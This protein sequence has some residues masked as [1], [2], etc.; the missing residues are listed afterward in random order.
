MTYTMIIL[1]IL[2]I[3]FYLLAITEAHSIV[4]NNTYIN[5]NNTDNTY[6]NSLLEEIDRL[7]KEVRYYTANEEEKAKMKKEYEDRLEIERQALKL[8][9]KELEIKKVQADTSNMLTKLEYSRF[10]SS[11]KLDDIERNMKHVV[12]KMVK[13]YVEAKYL[14]APDLKNSDGSWNTPKYN[15]KVRQNDMLNIYAR[16]RAFINDDFIEDLSLIYKFSE[17]YTEKF[18]TS[19]YILPTYDSYMK[20]VKQ[21]YIERDSIKNAE[22][23]IAFNQQKKIDELEKLLMEKDIP[24]NE[25]DLKTT[26]RKYRDELFKIY[27][28]NN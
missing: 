14:F 25:T 5:T 20:G 4:N 28:M 21:F 17:E 23:D 24:S 13:S 16:F 10:R 18:I 1:M 9:E 19:E 7:R 26:M 8:Q 15:E 12:D 11:L 27:K 22:Y 3:P 6:S 2:I